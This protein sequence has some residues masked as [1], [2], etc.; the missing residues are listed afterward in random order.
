MRFESRTN[1]LDSCGSGR[2][3]LVA[4]AIG[5]T[6]RRQSDRYDFDYRRTGN[7]QKTWPD[8]VI[9]VSAERQRIAAKHGDIYRGTNE[10]PR[11][12]TLAGHCAGIRTGGCRQSTRSM[13][14]RKI[15]GKVILTVS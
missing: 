13:G 15:I 12:W 14:S 10:T 1:N 11:R 8:V 6:S 2:R 5:E 7:G 4:R 9:K 3:Q